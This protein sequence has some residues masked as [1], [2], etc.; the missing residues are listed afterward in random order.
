MGIYRAATY[1]C[2]WRARNSTSL[3]SFTSPRLMLPAC[4]EEARAV[5]DG[6]RVN[7]HAS[8]T[9]AAT[10]AQPATS[11]KLPKLGT[12]SHGYSLGGYSHHVGDIST[13][14]TFRDYLSSQWEA[15]T[16]TSHAHKLYRR[17]RRASTGGVQPGTMATPPDS[18]FWRPALSKRSTISASGFPQAAE[19]LADS[20]VLVSAGLQVSM[21]HCAS[22]PL[23]TYD[24]L[25]VR[26]PLSLT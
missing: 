2:S 5:E 13:F 17:S 26:M 12:R 8:T 11:A 18:P 15:K 20:A 10:S 23:D 19:Q 14:R 9:E 1:T 21:R 24:V 25:C 6:M 3:L 7:L 22:A 16:L 4:S